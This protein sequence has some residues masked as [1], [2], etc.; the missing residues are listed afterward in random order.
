MRY[1]EERVQIWFGEG[2]E[3]LQKL[4]TTGLQQVLDDRVSL[5]CGDLGE[6]E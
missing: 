1:K 2:S 5:A 4:N 3:G 6:L